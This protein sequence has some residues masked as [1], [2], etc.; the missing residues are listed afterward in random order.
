MGIWFFLVL[1]IKKSEIHLVTKQ[2]LSIFVTAN[3]KSD[4]MNKNDYKKNIIELFTDGVKSSRLGDL[5]IVSQANNK[6]CFIL[7]MTKNDERTFK[8]SFLLDDDETILLAR[9]TS[10]WN[11]RREGLVIT[12]KRIVYI[13]NPQEDNN[14]RYDLELNNYN[15]VTYDSDSLQFWSTDETFFGIPKKYFFK[16]KLKSYDSDRALQILSKVMTNIVR[17]M[18]S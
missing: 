16:T 4:P 18:G 14:G 11:N 12:E 6:D 8:S 3:L 2:I 10:T 9:D 15:R 13:P 7:D 17:T 1:F 5:P